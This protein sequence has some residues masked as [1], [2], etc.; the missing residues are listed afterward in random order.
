MPN[1]SK[2]YNSYKNTD[3]PPELNRFIGTW[4]ADVEG[5]PLFI[6]FNENGNFKGYEGEETEADY[7]T[8]AFHEGKLIIFL[9]AT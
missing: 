1:K 7:S 6:E 9:K 8:W 3:V 5:E 2:T 4:K